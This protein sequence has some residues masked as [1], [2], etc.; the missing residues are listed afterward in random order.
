ME[1]N[2]TETEIYEWSRRILTELEGLTPN[3]KVMVL[4]NTIHTI[5]INAIWESL[6]ADG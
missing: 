3:Q 1:P 2:I 6:E 4:N 5:T